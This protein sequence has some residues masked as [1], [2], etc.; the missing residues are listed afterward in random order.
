MKKDDKKR[1]KIVL[2]MEKKILDKVKQYA[3][4]IEKSPEDTIEFVVD[5]FFFLDKNEKELRK[6]LRT[7]LAEEI[8]Y[9]YMDALNNTVAKVVEKED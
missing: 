5:Q 8:Y 1:V 7:A 2:H 4:K 9:E 6:T 3:E